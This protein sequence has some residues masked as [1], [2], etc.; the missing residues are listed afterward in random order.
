MISEAAGP[1]R[2]DVV[3]PEW[4]C[5]ATPVATLRPERAARGGARELIAVAKVTA[6]AG[7]V[8]VLGVPL[9][10]D[11]R[12]YNCAAVCAADG[13]SGWCPRPT[14]PPPANSTRALVHFELACYKLRDRARR[15]DRPFGADLLFAAATWMVWSWAWRSAKNLWAPAPPSG[16]LA[17]AGA[18][19]IIN[20]SASDE[21]LGKAEY[22]RELLRQQSGRTLS[23]Y[24]YAAAGPGNPPP[25]WFYSGQ[26]MIVEK[27]LY[28][29]RDGALRL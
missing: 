18:T 22:R 24:L 20:P 28:H 12:L 10:L 11:G 23:A 14:C 26:S 1:R 7:V 5:A 16:A 17:A 6:N 21:L 19:I 27:W 3:L 25:T 8:A 9:E 4:A 15:A 29:R 2:A 13:S